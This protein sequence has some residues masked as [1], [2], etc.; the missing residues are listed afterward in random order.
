MRKLVTIALVA[1]VVLGL[2]SFS[3]WALISRADPMY[4]A[5]NDVIEDVACSYMTGL[6]SVTVFTIGDK[7]GASCPLFYRF[8]S[9]P[10]CPGRTNLPPGVCVWSQGLVFRSDD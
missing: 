5:D 1:L 4:V 2:P 9:A 10:P 3:P 6:R 8:G 7:Y